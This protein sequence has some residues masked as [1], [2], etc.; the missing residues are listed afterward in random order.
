MHT[1]F[2]LSTVMDGQKYAD[3]V[4]HCSL[5]LLAVLLALATEHQC[6]YVCSWPSATG[7][8]AQRIEGKQSSGTLWTE[9]ARTALCSHKPSSRH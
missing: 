2:L 5:L 9:T 3:V 6:V 8:H 7:T 1:F 4:K